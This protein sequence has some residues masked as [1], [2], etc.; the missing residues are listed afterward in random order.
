MTRQLCGSYI[1]K[2]VIGLLIVSICLLTAA[3][4]QAAS[5]DWNPVGGPGGTWDLTLNANWYDS[6]TLANILWPNLATS[7]AVF[8]GGVTN[9]PWLTGGAVAVDTG[10]VT[11]N[12]MTFNLNG[13]SLT[14]N[15]STIT[16]SGTT[17]AITVTNGG[18][19]ANIDCNITPTADFAVGGNGNL[20]LGGNVS[21]T[22]AKVLTKSGAGILTIGGGTGVAADNTFI[23]LNVTNGTAI[24]NKA[25]TTASLHAVNTVTGVSSGATLKMSGSGGFQISGTV[26]GLEGTFD[27]NGQ[28][29]TNGAITGTAGTITNNANGTTSILT[30][31]S[32]TGT[33]AGTIQDHALGGT[34]VVALAVSGGT[35]T[36]SGAS[37]S[38]TGVTTISGG[39]LLAGSANAIGTG[40]ITFTGNGSLGY[41]AGTVLDQAARIVNSTAAIQIN[42]TT[43]NVTLA[44][45]LDATNVGGLTKNSSGTLTLSGTNLY[46]GTTTISAG[47]LSIGN[48]AALNTTTPGIVN[49]NGGTINNATGGLLTL[50]NVAQWG[51]SFGFSGDNI[52][53]SDTTAISTDI[54]RTITLGGSGKTLTFAAQVVNNGNSDKTLLV[55]GAGNTLVIGGGL[56]IRNTG[57]GSYRTE[58][59]GGTADIIFNGPIVDNA[60]GN[61]GS[62]TKIGIDTLTLA[63]SLANTMKDA[64]RIGGGTLVLDYSLAN[65]TK[66]NGKEIRVVGNST[67]NLTGGSY[68]EVIPQL[69]LNS[70]N[71]KPGV[72]NI[73]R[74]S[75]SSQIQFSSFSS[76]A[77]GGILN[78]GGDNIVLSPNTNTNGIIINGNRA[79][80]TVNNSDWGYNQT[81]LAGGP[82]YTYGTGGGAGTYT[83]YSDEALG[84]WTLTKNVMITDDVAASLNTSDT[85]QTL[86]IASNGGGGSL[87]LNA[88]TLSIDAGGVLV[89]PGT[90]NYTISNGTLRGGSP[91]TNDLLIYQNSSNTLTIASTAIIPDR[92]TSTRLTKTGLGTLVI[93]GQNTYTGTTYLTQGTIKI[94]A[95]T[96][97][98]TSGPLGKGNGDLWLSAGDY[99]T[100]S[101]SPGGTLDLNG[102][103]LGVN[104]LNVSNGSYIYNNSGGGT[105][106]LTVGN[107]NGG[108]TVNGLIANNDGVSTGGTVAVVKNGTGGIAMNYLNTF[109]GGLTINAGGFTSGVSGSGAGS[110]SSTSPFGTGDI[111]L[112][113]TI[114]YS[115]NYRQ[116][117]LSGQNQTLPNNL[118]VK[119]GTA[120]TIECNSQYNANFQLNGNISTTSGATPANTTLRLGSGWTPNFNLNG[121]L[122]NFYGTLQ[123][124]SNNGSSGSTSYYNFANTTTVGAQNASILMLTTTTNTGNNIYLQWLP[125]TTTSATIPIGDLNNTKVGTQTDS[126]FIVQNAKAGTTATFQIGWLNNPSSTYTG[127]IK[128]GATTAITAISKVGNGTLTLSGVNTYTGATTVNGGVLKISGAGSALGATAI[129]VNN[130]GKL[131]VDSTAALSSIP[132]LTVNSGGTL[133]GSAVFPS[134]AT[135]II[136]GGATIDMQDSIYGQIALGATTLGDAIA[137]VQLK[138]EAGGATSADKIVIGGSTF[139]IGA[140]GARISIADNGMTNG[141]TYTL[142]QYS[143]GS[144]PTNILLSNGTLSQLFGL[145][146][147]TLSVSTTGVT[148]NITGTPPPD[149]AYWT[150]A[151]GTTW[152]AVSGSNT[153]FTVSD[154]GANTHQF[155]GSNTIVHFTNSGA[156]PAITL[157]AS[158]GSASG[159]SF[160]RSS[161]AVTI[162]GTAG[163]QLTIG[164]TGYLPDFTP[165]SGIRL[166]GASDSMPNS[167]DVTI[168]VD[169]IALAN[170]FQTWTN[171]STSLLTVNSAISDGGS[172]LGLTFDKGRFLLTGANTYGGATTINPSTT[173]SLSGAGALGSGGDLTVNGSLVLGDTSLSVGHLSGGGS[174]V[175]NGSAAST[176]T[177]NETGSTTYSGTIANGTSGTTRLVKNGGGMI[178]LS[179]ANNYSGGTDINLGN[180]QIGATTSLGSGIVNLASTAI[181]DLNGQIITNNFNSLATTVT[182]T[183]TNTTSPAGIGDCINPTAGFQVDGPGDITLGTITKGSAVVVTR[184]GSNTGTLTLG[185]SADNAWLSIVLTAGCGTLVVD[186]DSTTVGT[187]AVNSLTVATGS[188]VQ[189]GPHTTVGG[190]TPASGQINMLDMEGGIVDLNGSTGTNSTV[191]NI[192][193]PSGSITNNKLGTMAELGMG[194]HDVGV[195][196]TYSGTIDDGLGTMSVTK[197][198][199]TNVQELGGTNTYTGPTNI[200][201][202]TLR[203]IGAGS[204]ANSSAI[205]IAAGAT[206]DVLPVGYYSTPTGQTISG[207]GTILGNFTH[208]QGTLVPGGTG[209]AGTLTF[210]ND[211]TITGSGT[212]SVN[213]DISSSTST[214]NDLILTN[215]TGSNV[216]GTVAVNIGTALG[217]TTGVYTIVDAPSGLLVGSS[218]AGWT[219]S[220]A[221]RRGGTAPA[222]SMTANQVLLTVTPANVAFNTANLKWSGAASGTWDVVTSVNWYNTSTPGPDMFYRGDNITFGDT[223]VGSTPPATTAVTLNTIVDPTSVTVNA[224]SLNYT[225]S[226]TGG[227]TGAT[228]LVK[229]GSGTLTITLTNA[230]NHS[231]TGGTVING[232]ILSLNDD[233]NVGA[234]AGM[235][236]INK[237][238]VPQAV[239]QAAASFGFATARPFTIGTGGGAIQVASGATL[240]INSTSVDFEGPLAIQGDG[241]L[242]VNLN[243]TPIVGAGASMS[244]AGTS[245]LNVGGTDPFT[246]GSTH[247]AV[248]NNGALN[249]TSGSKTV[250]ALSGTGNTS[251]AAS[252][253]LTA[254]S[255]VQN[256]VTLGIGARITIAPL[257]GGPTAGAGSLT[258]VPEPSTWAMLMLAAMGLGMYWRRS[259]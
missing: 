80:V 171:N 214:G 70:T 152:D 26:S 91:A 205:N 115:A 245:T 81:N 68:T 256:T 147:G 138:L 155:P 83:P 112:A 108:G 62:F 60:S 169:K 9:G 125:T 219:A 41:T 16:L 121:N 182:L 220:W 177:I 233:N 39:S 156:N 40:N 18:D 14:G 17:P 69:N 43:Q 75:G 207:S 45:V 135:T 203:F 185:G 66:F 95:T 32:G 7:T 6:G 111:T 247:M 24:L 223:Y 194:A 236:T 89:A 209:T 237:T 158:N 13:Y 204:I 199:S 61:G 85:V 19:S 37:N 94:G 57:D 148:L 181:L 161:S 42:T 162:G 210:T 73:T 105:S 134:T 76:F 222:V 58:R 30:I 120:N 55:N 186:K 238:G 53:F 132:S 193:G 180:V 48:A 137:P 166:T 173:V 101:P 168:S 198:G 197:V 102:N 59:V 27:L 252:T 110:S 84:N 172:M 21:S 146:T 143:L 67:I 241:A 12:A 117:L 3:T 36:I 141:G 145:N 176:L 31:N 206:F 165:F 142:M 88:Q 224:N 109:S 35:Q 90:G 149:Q 56:Q 51:N 189:Y 140:D 106:T 104:A 200:N 208:G 257:P 253:T 227:I 78:V 126:E 47:T 28:N 15:T 100:V 25:S 87:N 130:T 246:N 248:A 99:D 255:I 228:S 98:G 226:G 44:G 52:T 217:Y 190:F 201:E 202:G 192:N 153:N 212:T 196:A 157:G 8:G 151:L 259:R 160:E 38:Y 113:N 1:K 54:N 229:S 23:S 122:T 215:G 124:S 179:N 136:Q 225:I 79:C 133:A 243:G 218:V 119:S 213:F 29:E 22:S 242:T 50:A 184:L 2:Y 123:L 164:G 97:Q 187:H 235:V 11:V 4:S 191:R 188:L 114:A 118:I 144:A 240:T 258:A 71:G 150:G 230:A 216:G 129:T 244:I 232:G 128:D 251:V 96:N 231:Y 183:N 154:G 159:L 249:I 139:T 20:T 34:G 74:T 77:V 86:K 64:T 195:T 174:I 107:N 5:Y 175:N 178:I 221:D 92:N 131:F 254:T 65:V 127:L 93:N 46:T 234:D 49:L 250:G 167:G 63:G 82:I 116:L 10:G 239:L 170:S 33:F 211:M 163:Q 103:N 72:L